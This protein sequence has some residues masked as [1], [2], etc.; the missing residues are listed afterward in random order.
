MQIGYK[1]TEKFLRNCDNVYIL[2]HQSPDGD[3][4]GTGFAL[5]DIL[6]RMGKRSAVLCSDPF[7]EKF[8][9][10]T[11]VENDSAFEPDTVIAVDVADTRLLG[12]YEEIFSGRIDLCIDHQF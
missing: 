1:E 9:F 12:K 7:P 8:G 11:D 6:G 2:T 5:H 3:C 4:I 10:I